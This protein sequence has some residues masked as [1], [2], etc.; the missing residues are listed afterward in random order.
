MSPTPDPLL[1]IQVEGVEFALEPGRTYALGA[2]P[3]CDLRLAATT[4]P[5]AVRITLGDGG[6][7]VKPSGGRAQVLGPGDSLRL[8]VT[9]LRVVVDGGTAILLPDPAMRAARHGDAAAIAAVAALSAPTASPPR[10]ENARPP[11]VTFAAMMAA[12]LRRA[13]WFSLSVLLHALLLLLL[14]WL[15]PPRPDADAGHAT[16]GFRD[17]TDEAA[18]GPGPEPPVVILEPEPADPALPTLVDLPPLEPIAPPTA[19][20]PPSPLD[21]GLL[22]IGDQ[23][24]ARRNA[25]SKS[26]SDI[27]DGGMGNSGAFRATVTELR[28]TGL[29]VVFVV[30]STGSM[31]NSITAAKNGIDAMLEVLRALVPDARFGLIAYRDRGRREDYLL[32]VL[33]LDRDFYAAVNFVQSIDADGGGDVPEAV[34]DGLR[35]AFQLEFRPGARRVVVLAGDA[36]PHPN[37]LRPLLDEV[38]RFARDGRSYVHTL[39]TSPDRVAAVVADTFQ[40]IAAAG[41]GIAAG[42]DDQPRLLDQVLSLAFGRQFAGDL[43]AVQRTL[44]SQRQSPPTWALQ[45]ARSGGPE[46]ERALAG[47]RVPATLVHALLRLPHRAVARQLADLL[48]SETISDAGRQ[49]AAHVLQRQLEL[50][51]VPIDPERPRPVA[52][53][54]TAQLRDLATRLPE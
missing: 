9:E 13:P 15:F 17:C 37:E 47:D 32:R 21:R 3:H 51:N 11:A 30:D 10:P 36:P 48:G 4:A 34:L 39:I 20:P 50:A 52:R 31:G 54:V 40:Q 7:V 14:L 44:A 25:P 24:V 12:E 5:I 29:E 28:R 26:G 49:A 43:D 18:I 35:A 41:H 8:G 6:A 53:H 2:H 46:L 45:L 42:V 27:L 33:P 19:T 23:P 22:R 38:R 1:A 16:Y